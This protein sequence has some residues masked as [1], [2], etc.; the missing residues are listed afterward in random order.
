MEAI[1]SAKIVSIDINAKCYTPG[2]PA[3]SHD[4]TSSASGIV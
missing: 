4:N 3:V 2:S 1:F